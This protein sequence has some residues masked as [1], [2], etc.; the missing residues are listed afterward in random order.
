MFVA[1]ESKDGVGE[2]NN[3]FGELVGQKSE[4]SGLWSQWRVRILGKKYRLFFLFP[5]FLMEGKEKVV[6]KRGI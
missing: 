3:N 6:T 2:P 1:F 5:P 4:D